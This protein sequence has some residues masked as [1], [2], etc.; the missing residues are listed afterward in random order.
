MVTIEANAIVGAMFISFLLGAVVTLFI[1][2]W[3]DKK[4]GEKK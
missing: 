4:I 1:T 3:L 2:S